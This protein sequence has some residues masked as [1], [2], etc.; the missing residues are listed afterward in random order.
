M[1]TKSISKLMLSFLA[2][3]ILGLFAAYGPTAYGKEGVKANSEKRPRVQQRLDAL[4]EKLGLTD[5]QKADVR[6]IIGDEFKQMGDVIKDESLSKEQRQEKMSDIRMAGRAEIEKILTPEQKAK[7]AQMKEE[8]KETMREKAQ[9]R[10]DMRLNRLGEKLSLSDK[11]KADI[12][13]IIEDEFKKM[14]DVM[15]DQSLT[16]DQRQ[17]K[18]TEIREAGREQINKIL[19]DEQKAKFA[20]MQKETKERGSRRGGQEKKPADGNT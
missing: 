11:Q 12:K 15:K 7:F 5:K 17:A 1:V 20:E 9:G 18:I 19:T 6:E 10:V 2:V 8:A 14:G 16:R 3:L 13:P 4:S